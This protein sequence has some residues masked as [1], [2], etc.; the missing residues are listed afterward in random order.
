[1]TFTI[2]SAADL[3]GA[4]VASEQAGAIGLAH[5]LRALNCGRIAFLPV[6]PECSSSKFKQFVRGTAHRPAI[7]LLPDDDYMDRGPAG[8]PVAERVVRWAASI[9][10]HAA[11][12]EIQHYEAAIQT[13]QI[14]NRV[15]LIEASTQ[16][17]RAW[18]D[19]IL[20]VG[21][22]TPVLAIWPREGAHPIVPRRE[23]MQ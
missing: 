14:R 9:L 10:L 17:A 19:L 7:A 12:A 16:T 23:A 2:H 15:L 18:A 22:R 20:R 1:V 21:P 4:I 13:A 5:L 6:L 8:W 11:G 3:P